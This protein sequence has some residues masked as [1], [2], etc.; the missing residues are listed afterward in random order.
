MAG[1][2]EVKATMAILEDNL[3]L[4]VLLEAVA[5][6]VIQQTVLE[7]HQALAALVLLF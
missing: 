7:F 1:V 4:V 5:V 2:V 3:V 6:L